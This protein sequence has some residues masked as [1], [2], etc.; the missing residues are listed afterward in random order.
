M[1]NSV[2]RLA[3]LLFSTL[4]LLSTFSFVSAQTETA[5]PITEGSKVSLEYSLTLK[6]QGV[7]DS[8]VGGEAL[9]FVYGSKQIIPGLE[10]AVGGMK[11]GEQKNVEIAPEEA[12]GPV[13]QEAITTANIS[14]FP[15][16][17]QKVGAM[18]QTQGQDGRQLRG[19]VV[20]IEGDMVKVDF[21]HPLAGQ[22][23]YFEIKLL[24][25]E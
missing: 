24:N 21:N 7:I 3:T 10:K 16:D 19:K 4:L 12:Y 13:Y 9:T 2:T 22:T 1:K 18:V 11:V 8:N 25:V 15:A 20:S 23:L 14:Q 17:L 6:D 5:A